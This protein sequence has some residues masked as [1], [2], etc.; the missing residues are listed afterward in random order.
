MEQFNRIPL[1][2]FANADFMNKTAGA[3]AGADRLSY[4]V[5][6]SV[7]LMTTLINIVFSYAVLVRTNIGIAGIALVIGIFVCSL[8]F[9]DV[10]DTYNTNNEN[11]KKSR[12]VEYYQS[13]PRDRSAAAEMRLNN[14][15]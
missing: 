2:Q 11:R 10:N 5:D 15:Q 9:R 12:M 4:F 8:S 6:K 14:L 7:T 3:V 13:L 1:R